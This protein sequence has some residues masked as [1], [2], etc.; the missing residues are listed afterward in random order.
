MENA[1]PGP[2]AAGKDKVFPAIKPIPTASNPMLIA[3]N[4]L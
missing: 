4:T 2:T 1:T 3:G